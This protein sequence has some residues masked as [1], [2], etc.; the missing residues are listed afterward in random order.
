MALHDVPDPLD[1]IKVTS[2]FGVSPERGGLAPNST[3]PP[4]IAEGAGRLQAK[5]CTLDGEAVVVRPNG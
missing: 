3:W 4:A 2:A 1:R 5:S